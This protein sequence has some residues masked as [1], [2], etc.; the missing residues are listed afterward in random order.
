VATTFVSFF[1]WSSHGGVRAAGGEFVSRWKTFF[2]PPSKGGLAEN[3][4]SKLERL[5]SQSDLVLG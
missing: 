2:G 5:T 1:Y 3:L 4:Y